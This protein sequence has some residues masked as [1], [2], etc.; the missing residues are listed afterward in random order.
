MTKIT[1]R[2]VPLKYKGVIVVCLFLGLVC[3]GL[4]YAF[5]MKDRKEYIQEKQANPVFAEIGLKNLAVG[6]KTYSVMNG[7]GGDV[8]FTDDISKIE[9]Y[10]M[11]DVFRALQHAS[12]KT[13]N[14]YIFEMQD[15]PTGNNYKNNFKFI[16]HPSNGFRGQSFQIDKREL[17]IPFNQP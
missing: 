11:Q 2:I 9:E 5:L 4:C 12:K 7:G 1:E 17:V 6:M 14:G 3:V 15:N 13:Y 8:M 16:A 10:V